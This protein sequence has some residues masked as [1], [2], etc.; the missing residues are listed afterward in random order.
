MHC[1]NKEINWEEVYRR[2]ASA[3]ASLESGFKLSREECAR[4]LKK[5]TEI[6]ARETEVTSDRGENI[7]VVEF[8]LA[9]ERYAVQ[10]N[11]VRE[12]VVLNELIAIPCTPP[13]VSG[14]IIIRGEIISV[15]D[16]KI[17]FELPA[18]GLSDL[19]KVI[20]LQ[21]EDMTFGI[22][23]DSISGVCNIFLAELEPALPTMTGIREEYL[24]GITNGHMVVLDAAKL[25]TDSKIIVDEKVEL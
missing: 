14:I 6:L 22:L 25:L 12:I 3:Q 11:Y 19:N 24:T 23:A 16:I 1:R 18:G 15:I 20:I 2:L 5:R 10:T 21:Y 13:F 8:L 17:F 4:I 9:H 7:E